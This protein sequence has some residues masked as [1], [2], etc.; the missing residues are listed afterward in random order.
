MF[1]AAFVELIWGIDAEG[2]SLEEIGNH[3]ISYH[4]PNLTYPA[5]FLSSLPLS[6]LISAA[7]LSATNEDEEEKGRI[8]L[9][10]TIQ[11]NSYVT[12]D[13]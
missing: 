11:D 8:P 10:S 4:S 1:L 9:R 6:N 3:L 5:F 2:K 7:P 12:L 13:E